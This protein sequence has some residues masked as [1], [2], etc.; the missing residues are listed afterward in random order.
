MP[1]P[2]QLVAPPTFD[3][4]LFGLL[5]V[6]QARYDEPDAHWRNGV[7]WTDICGTPES[8]YDPYCVS[9]ATTPTK[10]P[11]HT[12]VTYGAT[13]FTVDARVDCSPVGF[14]QAEQRDRATAALTRQEQWRVERVFATGT[15]AASGNVAYPHLQASE[16]VLDPVLRDVVLQCAAEP[17]SGS[18]VLDIVEGIGRLEAAIADC[19]GGQAVLHVPLELGTQMFQWGVV[20]P[21]G[22]VLKTQTGNLVVLGAGY[23][24]LSPDGAVTPGALWVYATGPV[25]A[26]RTAPESFTFREMLNRETNTLESIVERTY[27]LGF[28]CCCLPAVP[29]SFGGDITGQPNSAF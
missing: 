15:V 6:V 16:D 2:R 21:D 13:P 14:S 25:F 7:T 23:P 1:G 3:P 8:V 26:Y 19:Y 27:V 5:S 4:R 24:G 12:V 17:I 28:S 22:A 9:G 10:E 20:K 11:T 29:I 18:T